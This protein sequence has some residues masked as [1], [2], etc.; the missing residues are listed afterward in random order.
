M[1]WMNADSARG[2]EDTRCTVFLLEEVHHVFPESLRSPAP[3]KLFLKEVDG[4]W[5]IFSLPSFSMQESGLSHSLK[6][7]HARLW[8]NYPS[9]RK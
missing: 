9:G 2:S 8:E 5:N 7:V 1:A 3:R 4:D 6:C